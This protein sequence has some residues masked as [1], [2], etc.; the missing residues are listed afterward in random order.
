MASIPLVDGTTF[1]SKRYAKKVWE[2][3]GLR[4]YK[5]KADRPNKAKSAKG[6]KGKGG[7]GKK[8]G[9]GGKTPSKKRAYSA[10]LTEDSSDYS[11]VVVMLLPFHDVQSAGETGSPR[12]ICE[13][14]SENTSPL[15]DSELLK[16]AK[17]I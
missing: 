16:R 13:I 12:Q 10:Q 11:A 4:P 14:S 9:K 6:G 1:G 17:I 2:E 3:Y 15:T 8:G 5:E 7:K